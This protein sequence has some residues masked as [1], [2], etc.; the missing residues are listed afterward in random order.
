MPRRVK[1]KRAPCLVHF[2]IFATN[3]FSM[4]FFAG[5]A[6]FFV[7]QMLPRSALDGARLL[8]R[9][10][11]TRIR[12]ARGLALRTAP[13][14]FDD[15]G[16]HAR[17]DPRLMY[18]IAPEYFAGFLDESL[19]TS[20][21][22]RDTDVSDTLWTGKAKSLF[23]I[24]RT[25]LSLELLSHVSSVSK[26]VC[27]CFTVGGYKSLSLQQATDLLR[28]VPSV[29]RALLTIDCA[30][31]ALAFDLFQL[32]AIADAIELDVSNH[33]ESLCAADVCSWLFSPRP[34]GLPKRF[35][36]TINCQYGPTGLVSHQA[37]GWHQFMSHLYDAVRKVHPQNRLQWT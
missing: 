36:A 15:R 18:A 34:D 26:D 4:D 8:S 22:V 1:G 19:I 24:S 17:V 33:F 14:E 37:S 10:I 32:P 3:Y 5:D 28:G 13:L 27:L 25:M 21:C 2:K 7:L 35:T 16:I 12:R 23:P 29:A 6:G 11:D 31:P 30:W 20:I 9:L